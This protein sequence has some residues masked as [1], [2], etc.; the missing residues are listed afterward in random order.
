MSLKVFCRLN[1]SAQILQCNCCIFTRFRNKKLFSLFV[2]NVKLRQK[3]KKQIDYG[4]S[5]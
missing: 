5:V 1:R 2:Q 4:K 3:K